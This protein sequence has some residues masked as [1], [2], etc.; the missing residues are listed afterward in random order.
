MI[1]NVNMRTNYKI[2]ILDNTLKLK[3][4]LTDLIN[5]YGVYV[6]EIEKSNSDIL[7][8]T[9]HS[10]HDDAMVSYETLVFILKYQSKLNV[11]LHNVKNDMEKL[12]DLS[13]QVD[14][15]HNSSGNTSVIESYIVDNFNELRDSLKYPPTV[16]W[17]ERNR[18]REL[19]PSIVEIIESVDKQGVNVKSKIYSI[20]ETLNI[21]YNSIDFYIKNGMT[22]IWVSHDYISAFKYNEDEME[23]I[24][25]CIS[26]I[27]GDIKSGILKDY[28]INDANL[29]IESFREN[30]GY[31][32]EENKKI[33]VY[34]EKLGVRK[35]DLHIDYGIFELTQND[36]SGQLTVSIAN[37][38][39]WDTD[40]IMSAA[41]KVGLIQSR[42]TLVM[43][44]A[45]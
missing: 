29:W 20:N 4:D 40:S 44:E 27:E 14:S 11:F 19:D 25:E 10:L 1:H 3:E 9:E 22:D 36:I 45:N 42:Y 32:L 28:E 24:D 18:F 34:F 15:Y 5:L 23:R 12:K 16:T 13:L 39:I 6:R 37:F 31:L 26:K 35:D 7:N 43:P 8:L 17:R 38:K 21:L 33:E 41:N 2:G 30:K